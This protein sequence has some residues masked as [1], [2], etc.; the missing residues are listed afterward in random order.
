MVLTNSQKRATEKWKKNHPEQFTAYKKIAD[1][2]YY[3]KHKEEIAT[4]QKKTYEYKKECSR[5]FNICI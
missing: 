4:R 3:D 5:L 2:I 1:K